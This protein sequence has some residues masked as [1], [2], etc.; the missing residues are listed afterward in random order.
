M[1]KWRQPFIDN[2]QYYVYTFGNHDS[3]TGSFETDVSRR[4]AGKLDMQNQPWSLTE[5]GPENI[6]GVSNYI[7]QIYSSRDP[8]KLLMNLWILD[9]NSEGCDGTSKI[10]FSKRKEFGWGCFEKDQ[11]EW[12]KA[13]SE[14][15]KSSFGKTKD[16]AFYHIP[17]PEVLTM[18]NGAHAYGNK[19]EGIIF[20]IPKLIFTRHRV[21]SQ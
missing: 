1:K 2:K 7:K 21:P 13:A 14:I 4:E 20:F 6:S 3:S 11:V 12:Y 15:L 9:T 19:Q 18:V 8:K 10:F 16:L 5:V 17:I